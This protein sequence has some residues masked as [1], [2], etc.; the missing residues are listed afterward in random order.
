MIFL[1][2]RKIK[3]ER[4]AFFVEGLSEQLFIEKLLTEILGQKNISIE[5]RKMKGGSKMSISIIKIGAPSIS[6]TA[7]YFFMIIDC[8]GETTIATYIRNQRDSLLSKG[9]SA[10]FGLLDVRP[11][12]S[13]NEIPKLRKM[14][15]YKL[16]QKDIET[17]FILS[18]MEIE[19]WFLAE[20]KHFKNIHPDLDVETI[21]KRNNFDPLSNTELVDEPARLLH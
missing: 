14:L 21:K 17:K 5:K 7:D 16:P 8:S 18:V 2:Q 13:R 6:P 19:S 15:Y 4:I 10:I 11:N 3:L 1:M 20:E 12:W 9:Y